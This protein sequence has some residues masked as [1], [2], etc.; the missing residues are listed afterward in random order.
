MATQTSVSHLL[1]LIEEQ[2][3]QAIYGTVHVWGESSHTSVVK[4][5]CAKYNGITSNPNQFVYHQFS[6]AKNPNALVQEMAQCIP[7][8]IVCCFAD[9]KRDNVGE[10]V[11]KVY[12]T[13]MSKIPNATFYWINVIGLVPLDQKYINDNDIIANPTIVVYKM[14]H[15]IDKFAPLLDE[16]QFQGLEEFVSP[17]PGVGPK[18]GVEE[19]LIKHTPGYD[20]GRDDYEKRQQKKE[21]EAEQ[22]RRYEELLEKKR[23]KQ[24]IEADRRERMG[25]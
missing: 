9:C 16:S 17:L 25:R 22:R 15:I 24:K 1:Q 7:R 10:W 3:Q 14:G 18:R 8:I 2:K 11:T 6:G 23:I 13:Y 19:E 21:I 5:A 4:E 12:P 20:P